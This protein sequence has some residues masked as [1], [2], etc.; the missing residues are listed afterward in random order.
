MTATPY[1]M[2]RSRI[3]PPIRTAHVAS[4][5]PAAALD[6]DLPGSHRRTAWTLILAGCALMLVGV[7]ADAA[8][9]WLAI[10]GLASALVG[11]SFGALAPA[12][13]THRS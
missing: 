8:F 6:G 4:V 3:A 7:L 2:R 11:L 12:H 5:T 1:E 13:G 10:P 9:L